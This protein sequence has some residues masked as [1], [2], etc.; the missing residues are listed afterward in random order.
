MRSHRN[1]LSISEMNEISDEQLNDAGSVICGQVKNGV[2]V[3]EIA[4]LILQSMINANV[5]KNEKMQQILQSIDRGSENKPL[6]P[7]NK[8]QKVETV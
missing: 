6:E 8:K 3:V 2:G 7:L 5:I 4:Q 1:D